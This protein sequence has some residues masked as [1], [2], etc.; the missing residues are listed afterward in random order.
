MN[1][2]LWLYG[3]R[4]FDAAG[5]WGALSDL[6]EFSPSKGEWAWMGGNNTIL[7]KNLCDGCISGQSPVPGTQGTPAAGNTPGGLWS[8]ESWTDSAGNFWLFG[9]W[10]YDTYG[11]SWLPNDLWEFNP[12]TNEWAWVNGP[13]LADAGNFPIGVYGVLGTPAAGN[14]PGDRWNGA[15]WTDTN[16][17]LWLFGGQGDDATGTE[18]ILNDLW[19]FNPSTNEWAWMGGSKILDCT[20]YPQLYCHE[21]GVYG[22]LGVAAAGNIPGSRYEAF[23]WKDK[24]GNLWLFGGIGFDANSNW[25]YLNDLWMFNPAKNEWAWMGGNSTIQ[26][27]NSGNGRYGTLGTP[28]AGNLPGARNAGASWTDK[29]GNFWL[30]GG[31]GLDAN[32]TFG[33]LNDLWRYQPSSATTI[34]A[35]ATPVFSPPAGT[36]ASA[37]SVAIS[38]TTPGATIYYTTDGVTTPTTASTPYTGA[39][40]VPASETIQAIAVAPGYTASAVSTAAYTINLPAPDFTISINP[41]TL[42]VQAGQSGTTTVAI[43]D[44]NGFNSNVS[45][46]C[47][48]LPAGAACSFSTQGVPTNQNLTYTTLTVTTAATTA[49]ARRKT[50]PLFPVS[51]LAAILCC[52]GLRRRRALQALFLSGVAFAALSLLSGCNASY[53]L[54]GSQPATYPI[55]VTASSGSLTHTATFSLTV[56]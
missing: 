8:A 16:G 43:A 22:A 51:A 41:N 48:G 9:G 15:T 7:E 49:A 37:Q 35:A 32:G 55:A 42:S 13:S 30:W 3:G 6:W 1:G 18:G 39:I 40:S 26:N 36:Y 24:I 11:Y 27:G 17:D 14:V 44:E 19:E 28:S 47:S 29:S 50:R 56:N 5:N 38:D 21:P 2:N 34:V 53:V 52:L 25:T 20:N 31:S 54:N 4:G 10:G 46:A 23:N 12:S 45:F 33:Y